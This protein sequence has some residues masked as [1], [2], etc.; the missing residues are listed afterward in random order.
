VPDALSTKAGRDIIWR[1]RAARTSELL[2]KLIEDPVTPS[3]ELP[4]L[5]RAF[6]FQ[7]GDGKRTAIEHLAFH[8][9]PTV[10]GQR[11]LI[12]SEAVNRLEGGDVSRSPEKRAAIEKVLDRTKGTM[13]FVRLVDR[14]EIK[15]RYPDLIALATSRP[16]NSLAVD[17]VEVLLRRGQREILATTLGGPESEAAALARVL[18]NAEDRRATPLLAALVDDSKTPQAVA[19]EAARGMAKTQQGAR[20]LLRR[21][22]DRSLAPDLIQAVA[23]ALQT[24]TFNDARLRREI[25]ALFPPP[26]ARND[27][28]LPPL[29]VMLRSR[30]DAARGKAVFQGVARCNTCHVVDGEGKEV[31]PNLSEIGSKLSREAFFESIL[32]PSAGISHNYE[33][34]SAST[35]NGNDVSGIKVSE[36]PTEIVLKGSDAIAHTLK[37]S[38]IEELKKQTVS[39]MPA[40]LQKLMTAQELI[41]VIEYVQTLKKK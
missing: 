20:D 28:P 7:A 10:P 30:G 14:F 8:P 12:D 1:S 4:R 23:F 19:V 15:D 13:A 39:L 34:W 38:E 11:S 9:S 24:S 40:D 18:G 17:A 3:E 6:D 27:K 41:D 31:G 36:T 35:V 33:T 29:A 5:F 25:E 22:K 16:D 37:K 32:F 26:P 2:A 21:I